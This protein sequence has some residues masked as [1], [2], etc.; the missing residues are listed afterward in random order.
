MKKLKV[1]KIDLKHWSKEVFSKLDLKINLV[2]S[3]IDSVDDRIIEGEVHLSYQ[4]K[5]LQ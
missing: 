4:R 3:K 2:A 1:L 5:V